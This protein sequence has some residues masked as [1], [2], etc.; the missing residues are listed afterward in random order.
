[1]KLKNIQING[2]GNIEDKNMQFDDKINLV[3]GANESGK[4]TVMGFIKAIFYGVNRNKAGNSFSEFERYKPWK[5]IEFSGK[6]EYEISGKIYSVFRDFNRNNAKIYDENGDEITKQFNKDKSRGVLPIEEEFNIDEETFENT[7]FITQKS[8]DVDVSSQKSI[9]EKLTNMFQSGD[10]NTSYE[11]VTRKLEK[12]LYEEVGTDRTQ[13]KPKNLTARELALK[14]I[15]RDQLLGKK[16]RQESIDAETKSLNAKVLEIT[17]DIETINEVYNVKEKYKNL[18]NEKRNVYDA[19]QKVIEK[20][21]AEN[22]K[23]KTVE[24]RRINLLMGILA[25]ANIMVSVVM[26]EYLLMF[27][28][29]PIAA[30]LALANTKRKKSDDALNETNPFDI[31]IEELKKKEN[32]ELEALEKSGMKKGVIDRKITELRTLI[33]GYEKSKNDYILQ[34]HKLELEAKT[35]EQGINKLNELEE[36]IGRL[37]EKKNKICEKEESLKLALE[38][39]NNSYE[40]LKSK[41]VPDVT[42]EIQKCVKRTTNNAYANVKYSDENGIIIENKFGEMITLDKLSIGTMDQIYLGFRLAIQNKLANIPMIL[43]ETFAYYDDERLENVMKIL[44]NISMDKQIIIFTCS[45]RE[46]KALDKVGIK[47][48]LINM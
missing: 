44:E 7:A 26:K 24:R 39:F 17:K 43:D 35:I 1:M 23:K 34:I 46:K 4:S 38:V 37:I 20:Q 6:A 16:E 5:D 30:V 18:L 15:Q 29:L 12:I 45:E 19:E 2:F 8:V 41:I 25:V 14:E 36:D 21:K 22:E 28:L 27:A 13:N 3:I 48:N 47:Y 32:K 40:E 9:V 31:V 33:D 42:E 11:N 10:E